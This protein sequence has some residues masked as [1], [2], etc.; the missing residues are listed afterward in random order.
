MSSKEINESRANSINDTSREEVMLDFESLENITDEL[1]FCSLFN[2]GE[3]LKKAG[4]IGFAPV[5]AKEMI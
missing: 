1:N 3:S 4:I 2:D 5:V